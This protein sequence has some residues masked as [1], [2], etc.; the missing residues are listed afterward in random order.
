MMPRKSVVWLALFSLVGLTLACNFSGTPTATA[1]PTPIPTQAAAQEGSPAV[2]PT[3]IPLPT[4]TAVPATATAAATATAVPP[5]TA[6]ERPATGGLATAVPPTPAMVG[7]AVR[8]FGPGQQDVSRLE[9]GA[10]KSYTI[11]GSKFQPLFVFAEASG[12]ADVALAVAA[13]ADG[14]RPLTEANFSPAG[15]PEVLVFS[16]DNDGLFSLIVANQ[17]SGAGET[18]VYVF[19]EATDTPL[20]THYRG[21]TL[22][23]GQSKSYTVQSNGGRPVVAFA[24]PLDQSDLVLKFFE[25]GSI[26]NEANFSGP[27]SAEAAFVLPLRTT[28]YTIEISTA[29]GGA[30]TFTLIVVKLE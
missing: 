5:A 2:L 24:E 12:E 1:V 11:Q 3:A 22:T 27:G 21:E 6:T 23:A 28:E 19:D 29:N 30:A 16:P 17:G 26:A 20:A 14:A 25:A 10:S 13:S 7:T 9:P 8:L 15:R 18:A 4:D